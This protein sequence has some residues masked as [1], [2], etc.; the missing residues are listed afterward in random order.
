MSEATV[1]EMSAEEINSHPVSKQISKWGR[2]TN[3]LPAPSDEGN[4]TIPP[5]ELEE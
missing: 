5:I 4:S 1:S 2:V 3:R